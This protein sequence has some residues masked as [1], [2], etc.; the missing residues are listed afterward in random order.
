MLSDDQILLQQKILDLVDAG[1]GVLLVNSPGGTGKTYTAVQTAIAV[2][3][4]DD[5]ARVVLSAPTHVAKEE[6]ASKI[7][8][9]VGDDI[10]QRIEVVTCARLFGCYLSE[11]IRTGAVNL[12]SNGSPMI[13]RKWALIIIDEISAL[14]AKT[15]YKLQVL[16]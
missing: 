6:L 1:E 3:K 2:L 12:Y 7:P 8:A 11:D 16:S 9:E 5:T 13:L 10:R 4:A 15:L 14:Y